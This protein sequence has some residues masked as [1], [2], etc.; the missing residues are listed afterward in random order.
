MSAPLFPPE[1]NVVMGNAPL[2]HLLG[3]T[4]SL[5]ALLVGGSLII[6]P[7][8]NLDAAFDAIQRFR[9][10]TMIGVPALYRM[11]LEHSRLDQYDLGSLEYGCRGQPLLRRPHR[12]S[13]EHFPAR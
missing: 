1:D 6:Q 2:F 9:A 3:Q 13:D 11:I 10:R 7:R 12:G 4:C 8:I 5:A